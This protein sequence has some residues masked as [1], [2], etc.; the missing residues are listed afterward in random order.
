MERRTLL[1]LLALA[2]FVRHVHA[3]SKTTK[4]I[5]EMQDNWKTLLAP[6]TAVPS[7]G[8]PLKL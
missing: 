6:G 4:G 2:P 3:Q 7:A 8:E 5:K 1:G